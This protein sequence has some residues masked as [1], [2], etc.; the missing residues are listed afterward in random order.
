MPE[1]LLL[2]ADVDK[3]N[4]YIIGPGPWSVLFFFHCGGFEKVP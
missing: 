1:I 3:I 2:F 4:I